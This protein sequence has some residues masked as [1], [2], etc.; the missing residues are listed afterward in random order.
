VIRHPHTGPLYELEAAYGR[1]VRVTGDHS[2]FVAGPG[3]LPVLK[4]GCEVREGDLLVAPSRVPLP[5]RGGRPLDLVRLLVERRP[6]LG[7]RLVLEGPGVEAYHRARVR[8]G[9]VSRPEPEKPAELRA[10][11]VP[12]GAVVVAAGVTPARAWEAGH[13]RARLG[14]LRPEAAAENARPYVRVVD[15]AED[16]VAQLG[17]GVWIAP[18]HEPH[19]RLWRYLPVDED[20]MLVLGFF[21]ARGRLGPRAGVRLA[22]GGRRERAAQEVAAAA[23]RVF[24][25]TPRWGRSRGG[26]RELRIPHRAVAAVLEAIC[27]PQG[28][29]AA[30]RR[31]PEVVFNAPAPLRRAYLR[32]Y[33]LGGGTVRRGGLA[34]HAGSEALA[35]DLVYLLLSL[36]VVASATRREPSGVLRGRPA[37]TRR[38]AFTVTV[39]HRPWLEGLEPVWR[40]HPSADRVRQR[41]RSC[42][43]PRR[44]RRLHPLGGDLVGLPVRAVRRVEP[45]SPWVYDFSVDEDET[46][47]AGFGAVCCHNTDADV[48]GAHI[49]TLLLTF[50]YRYMRELIE[51]GK[52]YVAVPPL[53]LVRNGKRK[54]YAYS[55][56]ELAAILKEFGE[57]SE[58]QRYK[59]LG[60]MNP[61][62]LWETTMDPARRTLI[63]VE[64]EDAEE[65]D[66]IFRTLMGEDVEPRR[67]FIVRY[68]REV[69]NLDI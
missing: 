31:V 25:V 32:G 64:L 35:N 53:Y 30:S 34:F 2:V 57:G 17:E 62:Q 59:G 60:E 29:D 55:D 7:S 40:D 50:F 52:V 66:R 67:Q 12:L 13:S 14:R 43:K 68:A 49:R 28:L 15:V 37:S 23:R 38:T 39:T 54:R 18:A 20:L 24:G 21:T 6:T 61:E 33:F 16:D 58:V 22:V 56:E 47:V 11:E 48:D 1:R 26:T 3:G 45:T 69:R 46:F 8:Q 10:R 44:A 65:A 27:G 42:A 5:D 51:H 63:R 41:L 4:R 19:E 36:G 9:D